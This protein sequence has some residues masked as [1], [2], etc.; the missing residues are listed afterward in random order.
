MEG[1]SHWL[2]LAQK[3]MKNI[4]E[5]DTFILHFA[6]CISTIPCIFPIFVVKYIDIKR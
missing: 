3:K 4:C 2:R 5:A 1:A 6:F